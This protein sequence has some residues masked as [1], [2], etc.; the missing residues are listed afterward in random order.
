MA[1]AFEL[2]PEFEFVVVALGVGQTGFSEALL[3]SEND[4]FSDVVEENLT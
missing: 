3:G 1:L 4:G 2:F